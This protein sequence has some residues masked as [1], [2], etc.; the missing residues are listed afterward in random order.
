MPVA[1]FSDGQKIFVHGSNS[2]QRTVDLLHGGVVIWVSQVH[3]FYDVV[4]TRVPI[5]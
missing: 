2:V 5:S 3:I 1:P 4:D